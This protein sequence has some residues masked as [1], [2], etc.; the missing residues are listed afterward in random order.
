VNDP[1]QTAPWRRSGFRDLFGAYGDPA[2]F[3]DLP[4]ATDSTAGLVSLGFMGSALRRTMA[5]WLAA[6]AVGLVVGFGLAVLRQPEPAV[7]ATL[8]LD[9]SDNSQGKEL[10]TDIAIAESTPVAAA[11][12]AQLGINQSPVDFLGTYSLAVYGNSAQ[13]LTMTVKGPTSNAAAQRASDIAKQFLAFRAKYLQGQLNEAITSLDQQVAKAQ[14]SLNSINQKISQATANPSSQQT[15]LASLT[16][17]QTV[18]E[19]TLST[20]QQDANSTKVQDQ[21]ATVQMVQGSQVLSAPTPVAHSAKKS[22]VLYAVAGL[23]GG[24]VIAMAVIVIGSITTD[25]LRRRDDIAIAVGAPVKLSVGPLRRRRIPG[26]RSNPG[27][28]NRDM[29]RFVEHLRNAVPT[30]SREVSGLAVVT[31]DDAPT[32]ARAVVELAITSSQQRRR[33]V[34]ADLSAGFPAAR[35]LGV[36]GPG[37]STVSPEGVPIA[38]VVPGA[39][40]VAPVGPFAKRLPRSAK[41]SEELAETCARADLILSIVTLDPAFDGN[42]LGTWAT[43]AVTVVTAGE[44]TATRLHAAGEMIRLA[45]VRLRSVVVLDVDQ[46]DE[47]LGTVIAEYQ[48]ASAVKLWTP[49]PRPSESGVGEKSLSAGGVAL[50]W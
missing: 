47:S 46:G 16:K 49:R 33:V 23:I 12:V 29:K 43:D 32:V 38:V 11:V 26:L 35:E 48:P 28:Q 34:L 24:L 14:Q 41:A 44:S 18:A 8:L 22:M 37:I 17:Q 2:E 1:Q 36:T 45:G 39:E 20:V 10:P 25:R 50:V 40:E 9:T 5:V 6:A 30:D 31:V 19:S 15:D 42:Y 7:T 13:V 3:G 21:A 4:S 27:Q